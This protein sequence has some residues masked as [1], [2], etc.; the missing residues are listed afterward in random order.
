MANDEIHKEE[1]CPISAAT[2]VVGDFWTILIIRQLAGGEC[3]R[4][5]ELEDAI[6]EITASS[7]S[8]KLKKLHAEGIVQRK[9][10]ES[11]PPRVDY[12][13]TEKGMSLKALVQAIEEFGDKYYAEKS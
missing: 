10:H 6:P 2:K 5:N 11:I 8:S 13:L 12:C 3:K 7:L 9:Q 4:F 1:Y